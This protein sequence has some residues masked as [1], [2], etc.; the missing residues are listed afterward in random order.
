MGTISLTAGKPVDILVEYTNTKPP[1]GPE[2]DRSQPALMRGVVR[3]CIRTGS[4]IRTLTPVGISSN[5]V[6]EAAR[7]SIRRR[8]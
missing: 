8:L 5:S 1:E 2:A 4:Y 6:W 3:A 7:R